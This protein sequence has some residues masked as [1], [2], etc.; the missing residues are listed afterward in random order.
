[1]LIGWNGETMPALSL[2]KELEVAA[3]AGYDG[4]ELFVPKLAPYLES[5]AAGDL[6]RR[7]RENGLA[8]LAMNGIENINL[9][10]PEEFTKVKEECRWLSELS[11]E[12]G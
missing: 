4:A 5:H 6:V 2:D 7:L 12:I 11:Q 1:V 9:R 8:P 3:A 10:P